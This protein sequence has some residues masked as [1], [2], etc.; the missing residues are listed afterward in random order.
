[1]DP[2]A[3]VYLRWILPG[4]HQYLHPTPRGR[5][6]PSPMHRIIITVAFRADPPAHTDDMG[7][8]IRSSCVAAA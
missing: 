7:G 5:G 8:R 6:G 3:A 4:Q 2:R 1:M